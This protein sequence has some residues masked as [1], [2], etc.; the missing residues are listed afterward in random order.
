MHNENDNFNATSNQENLTTLS[1]SQTPIEQ[2]QQP[3]TIK[4]TEVELPS[5]ESLSPIITAHAAHQQHAEVT[6]IVSGRLDFDGIDPELTMHL[7]SLHWNRQHHAC[8]C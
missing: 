7:L 2:S 4:H 8:E 5:D 3:S 1:H 6:N